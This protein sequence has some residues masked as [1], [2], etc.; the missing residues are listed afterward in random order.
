MPNRCAPIV[1]V[2][3]IVGFGPNDAVFRQ[4]VIDGDVFRAAAHVGYAELLFLGHELLDVRQFLLAPD[5]LGQTVIVEQLGGGE[6][7]LLLPRLNCDA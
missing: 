1:L 6:R 4:T 7:A 2:D 5:L 3:D